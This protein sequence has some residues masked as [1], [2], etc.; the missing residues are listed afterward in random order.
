MAVELGERALLH[1][2]KAWDKT[3]T[4]AFGFSPGPGAADWTSVGLWFMGYP[5]RGRMRGHLAIQLAEELN[6]PLTLATV[7][8]H[9]AFLEAMRGNVQDTFEYSRKTI[10]IARSTGILIRQTEGEL[11]EGW[12]LARA[13]EADRG[14]R[15]IEASL[16]LWHQ[17]G[18]YIADP[19]WL[20]FL[21]DA[22]RSAGRIDEAHAAISAAVDAI[23][24]HGEHIWE[25]GVHRLR[26]ELYLEGHEADTAQAE[27][28]FRRS[29]KVAQEQGAKLLELSAAVSLARLWRGQNK[30][31]EAHELLAQVYSRFTEGFDTKELVE[32][33]RLLE[34]LGDSR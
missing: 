9:R 3:L 13:G 30:R 26:G 24:K 2:E 27:R 20:A 33:G 10:E 8:V 15:Q 14:I 1:Y 19:S 11:M 17:M 6:H 29:I 28:C 25:S 21:A 4:A 7:L 22:C 23:E 5:D 16:A 31:K 32:A 12:A 18:A 34:E